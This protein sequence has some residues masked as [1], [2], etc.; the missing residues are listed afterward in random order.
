[1]SYL[2]P[3]MTA[4]LFPGERS[5]LLQLLRGLSEVQW[6]SPTICTGWSVHDVALHLLGGDI[7]IISAHRDG[8]REQVNA[9]GPD[10]S[11][12][13]NLV[14]FINQR[15]EMWVQAMRRTSPRL[16][17]E[18]LQMTGEAI[19]SHFAQLDQFAVG[20][21]VS[22]AGSGPAPVWLDTAREYTERW[23]HQQHIRDAVGQP[24]LCE[25]RWLGPVLEAFVYALPHTLRLNDSPVGTTAQ[26]IIT[27]E[28]GGSWLVTRTEQGWVFSGEASPFPDAQVTLDQDVAWRLFT[29]GIAR[30]EAIARVRQE[31]NTRL[32]STMLDMVSI[33]A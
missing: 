24:G 4:E 23:L 16:L 21:P 31:G 32:T 17:C 15:N 1:M 22:W 9:S 11:R 28:A 13:E 3:V 29:R 25:R 6:A 18:F 30:E 2:R 19:A 10:L 20:V 26:L 5:A 33:I 7:G 27:G 8:Y 14:P 12:W